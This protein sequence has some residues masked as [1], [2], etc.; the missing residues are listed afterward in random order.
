MKTI[1]D[2]PRFG[3]AWKKIDDRDIEIDDV[4]PLMEILKQAAKEGAMVGYTLADPSMAEAVKAS[5]QVGYKVANVWI[6]MG[7]D[8]PKR[9]FQVDP[10]KIST[11][12]LPSPDL[13]PPLMAV[14]PSPTR[15]S[16]NSYVLQQF[17]SHA[18]P[19]IAR[20][21]WLLGLGEKKRTSMPD[22]VNAGK[23]VL[24]EPAKEVEVREIGSHKLQNIIDDMVAAMSKAPGVGLAAPQI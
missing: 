4:E 14:Q 9:L 20:A 18:S 22:I 12:S 24:H 2:N 1:K 21:V 16:S 13:K 7:L 11:P 23:P 10:E 5:L 15:M 6:V 8:L 3:R 17:Y 19:S